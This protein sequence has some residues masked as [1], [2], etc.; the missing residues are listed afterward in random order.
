[1]NNKSLKE[2]F[3][4]EDAEKK[5]FYESVMQAYEKHSLVFFIGAGV[6]RLM[7]VPSW[8][9]LA[10]RL[11]KEAFPVYCEQIA[12]L[13]GVASNKE[14]ITI[15]YKK[16]EETGELHKFYERFGDALLPSANCLKEDNIYKLL[17]KFNALFLTTNADNLF[18]EVLGSKFCH[19]GEDYI[20]VK[21]I[22]NRK[23]NHL[24]Y[25]HGHYTATNNHK[26]DNLVFTADQ[27]VE[28]YNQPRFQEF[29][30]TLFGNNNTIIFI[31]YGLNEFE[32]IDY[33]ATKAGN[34]VQS[35]NKV[36]LLYPFCND[37][38]ILYQAKKSYFDSLH[39]EMIPY[40]I[41]KK[42]YVQLIDELKELLDRCRRKTIVPMIDN[43]RA[44]AKE[45]SEENYSE[46]ARLLRNNE[47][48]S[49]EMLIIEEIRNSNDDR[50]VKRMFDDGFY[51]SKV[52]DKKISEKNW[53]ELNL[54]IDWLRSGE[55][56]AQEK[57]C[58]ILDLFDEKKLK[59]LSENNNS[60]SSELV[61][62]SMNLDKEH[63]QDKYLDMLKTLVSFSRLYY[64]E[65]EKIFTD[66]FLTWKNEFIGRLLNI[67]YE[68]A[69]FE[70]FNDLNSYQIN[71]ICEKIQNLLIKLKHKERK[72]KFFVNYYLSLINKKAS[73][74][75][76]NLLE[77]VYDVDNI[78]KNHNEY[79]TIVLKEIRF[80]FGLISYKSKKIIID[81]LAQFSSI[82]SNKMAL[83]L[84][85]KFGVRLEIQAIRRDVFDNYYVYHELFLAIKS[86][87]ENNQYDATD[88]KYIVENTNYANWGF[89]AN[90]KDGNKI[91][92]SRRLQILGLC[93]MFAEDYIKELKAEGIEPYDSSSAANERDYVHIM[94]L[95]PNEA[96]PVDAFKREP[97]ET[98][99][100]LYENNFPNYSIDGL[101]YG[102][103][104]FDFVLQQ[105]K[106][107]IQKILLQMPQV[108]TRK[109]YSFCNG[110]SRNTDKLAYTDLFGQFC[111]GILS[112]AQELDDDR[113]RLI[114]QIFFILNKLEIKNQSLNE[115]L[116]LAT[117][118]WLSKPIN[119]EDVF[120]V[121]DRLLGN[122][123]NRGDYE[124]YLYLIR[125]H[126]LLKKETGRELLDNEIE[127]ILETLKIDKDKT[128]RYTLCYFYQ[129][130]YYIGGD[131]VDKIFDVFLNEEKFDLISLMLCV[132]NS[133]YLFDKLI[134]C[135]KREFLN[136]RRYIKIQENVDEYLVD[137]F[138]SYIVSACFR[139]VIAFDEFSIM[140]DDELFLKRYFGIIS[141][142]Y[143]EENFNF[144]EWILPFWNAVKANKNI[145][146]KSSYAEGILNTID[147]N[148]KPNEK[149]LDLYL[150]VI[151]Y[152]KEAIVFVHR[153]AK[154]VVQY[155]DINYEKTHK[156]VKKALLKYMFLGHEELDDIVAKYKSMDK[157]RECKALL[158]ELNQKGNLSVNLLEEYGNELS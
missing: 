29:L 17:S 145:E 23:T 90:D 16:F 120:I 91:I 88:L 95:A 3:E 112:D 143:K 21:A 86:N 135:I 65:N 133:R 115:E 129:N 80:Y 4:N 50:W 8:E 39:I 74:S 108:E 97:I 154:Y 150:E 71:K 53:P 64:L 125:C 78:E 68:D 44:F 76:Y 2:I 110:L 20:D 70:N 118:A 132:F 94:D 153:G 60:I 87:I 52:L 104:F 106:K 98:W 123:I 56:T 79:W 14:K 81:K 148:K 38:N 7:G 19:V 13:K 31:G 138:Y 139:N 24:Y 113:K 124:K 18:E 15:A 149:M 25:L 67:L 151:D 62:M 6:S 11:I 1:M 46:I 35:K 134:V 54:V 37:E 102:E 122:L 114:K 100:Q 137:R 61:V 142:L 111:L 73:K 101:Y 136:K 57:T 127:K 158:N 22:E 45:F 155:F 55:I 28:R 43:I 42:G 156:L 9:E 83:Y 75:K 131:K 48:K 140:Y 93:P 72:A 116:L 51:S 5:E 49:Y 63:I 41:S 96:F 152:A 109:L 141:M 103:N 82:Y 128:L 130:L 85:R 59:V 147:D 157:K 26:K 126:M 146:N 10:D 66:K 117:Y 84:S 32:I 33:V 30:K 69:D 105:S 40:D 36:F 58:E 107:D 34:V 27:Y 99:V 144:E 89:D 12:I 92:K 77:R 121:G 47:S 119:L